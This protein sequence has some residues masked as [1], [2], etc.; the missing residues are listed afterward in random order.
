[1]KFAYYYDKREEYGTDVTNNF[2]KVTSGSCFDLPALWGGFLSPGE[3]VRVETG[4]Y[5]KFPDSC[6]GQVCPRSGLA[7]K[8]GITV[9]NS[10]GVIDSD[11]R[12][13]ISVILYNTGV[14]TFSWNADDR[15]AQLLILDIPLLSVSKNYEKVFEGETERGDKGFGSSGVG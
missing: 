11:Y 12:G 15:I 14:E 3:R 8:Y 10:P 13:D 7:Y 6:V 5:M 2:K 9:L 1:M 4:I